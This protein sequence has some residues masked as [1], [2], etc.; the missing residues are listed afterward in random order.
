MELLHGQRFHEIISY[1]PFL[2]TACKSRKWLSWTFRQLSFEFMLIMTIFMNAIQCDSWIECNTLD[3]DFTWFL[4]GIWLIYGVERFWTRRLT[5][6]RKLY[7]QFYVGRMER[8]SAYLLCCI[9]ICVVVSISMFCILCGR[10]RTVKVVWL[11]RRNRWS[12]VLWQMQRKYTFEVLC[13]R[14]REHET[15][16]E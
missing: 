9:I 13:R 10:A 7:M 8:A 6:H 4:M 2:R 16:S 15:I 14:T 11:H 5:L 3:M 12:P 1:I